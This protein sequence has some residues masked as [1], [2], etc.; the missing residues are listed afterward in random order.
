M[1]K[2]HSLSLSPPKSVYE[3]PFPDSAR[4]AGVGGSERNNSIRSFEQHFEQHI[5]QAQHSVTMRSPTHLR[6][7]SGLPDCPSEEG[8]DAAGENPERPRLANAR[9]CATRGRNSTSRPLRKDDRHRLHL[10][11]LGTL[12]VQNTLLDQLRPPEAKEKQQNV[13]PKNRR[14][15]VKTSGRQKN[16]KARNWLGNSG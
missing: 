1:S 15:H 6:A 13:L 3:K 11:D 12:A 14:K 9:L 4:K 2:D 8:T 16:V 7:A 10:P 5:V